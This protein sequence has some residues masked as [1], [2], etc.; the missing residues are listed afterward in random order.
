MEYLCLYLSG[1]YR[2]SRWVEKACSGPV[3]LMKTN[4]LGFRL[5]HTVLLSESNVLFLSFIVFLLNKVLRYILPVW[6][7]KTRI[8]LLKQLNLLTRAHLKRQLRVNHF[9]YLLL[10]LKLSLRIKSLSLVLALKRREVRPIKRVTVELLTIDLGLDALYRFPYLVHSVALYMPSGFFCPALSLTFSGLDLLKHLF[11][12][13]LAS[14]LGR[15]SHWYKSL[16]LI[17]IFLCLR[18]LQE[19]SSNLGLVGRGRVR[20]LRTIC[21]FSHN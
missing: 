17:L 6:H 3:F 5:G 15:A 9:V 7:N 10:S 19:A 1:R 18:R 21:K 14:I 12:S 2:I 20:F 16:L 11:H 13:D 4:K 8:H